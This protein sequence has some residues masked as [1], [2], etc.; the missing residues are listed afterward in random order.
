[1]AVKKKTPLTPKGEQKKSYSKQEIIT[2]M[3]E[4]TL[5]IINEAVNE[6][7]IL[8]MKECDMVAKLGATIERLENRVSIETTMNVLMEFTKWLCTKDIEFAKKHN[9]LQDSYIK[10]IIQN[11]N[12]KN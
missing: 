6:K 9:A 1:M 11:E 4:Q 8:T 5:M 3:H 2:L 7:R 10:T 12:K